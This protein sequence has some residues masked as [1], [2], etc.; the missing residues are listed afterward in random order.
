VTSYKQLGLHM[1]IVVRLA[2]NKAEEA[3][4]FLNS[5]G[6]HIISASEL[7]S[8]A[9]QAVEAAAGAAPGAN[10]HSNTAKT[11]H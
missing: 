4:E 3:M 5:S 11:N 9:R 1:P 2:G 7:D 10:T 6:L 8:A